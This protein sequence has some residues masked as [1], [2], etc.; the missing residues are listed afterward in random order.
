MQGFLGLLL[1]ALIVL[2]LLGLITTSWWLV[3]IPLW[4]MIAIFVA[5][6]ALAI[7]AQL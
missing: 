6:L 1:V 4:I 5:V 7:L 2:K 3:L